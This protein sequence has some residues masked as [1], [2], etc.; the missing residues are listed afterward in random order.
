MANLMRPPLAGVVEGAASKPRRRKGNAMRI[1]INV[2]G[3]I[4]DQKFTTHVTGRTDHETGRASIRLA[5]SNCPRLWHPFNYSDP[6]VLLPGYKEI[7]G[8]L[9]F[10]SLA[11]TSFAAVTIIDFGSGLM[12]RKTAEI[13]W[14]ANELRGGYFI[15]GGAN[16]PDIASIEPYEEYMHPAGDGKIIAVG[17]ARWRTA[18]GDVIE[19]FVSTRYSFTEPRDVLKIPQIRRSHVVPSLSSDGLVFDGEYES[20]VTPL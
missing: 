15:H 2:Y 6:L 1:K 5:Y 19:A 4:N 8:G 3:C 9:N 17:M 12:L 16:C 14:E 20:S 18:G 11:H 13:R 10:L 7:D